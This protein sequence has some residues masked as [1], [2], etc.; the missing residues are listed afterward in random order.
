[1]L[2]AVRKFA[3]SWVAAVLIGLLVISFALFGINDVF[4]GGTSNYVVTAGSRKVST[5]DF[6]RI[7]GV[8][9]VG[10]F[11]MVRALTPL[12]QKNPGSGVVNIS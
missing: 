8:N 9:V 6:K 10:A 3:K 1:M 7:Y 4:K 12:L 5:A 2:L 11:Q